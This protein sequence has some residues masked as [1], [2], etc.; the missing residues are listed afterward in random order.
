MEYANTVE[1]KHIKLSAV[2]LALKT[3]AYLLFNSLSK[4]TSFTIILSLEKN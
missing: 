3:K 1:K 2:T 4:N